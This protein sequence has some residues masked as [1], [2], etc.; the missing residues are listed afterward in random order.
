MGREG[1]A[2][3]LSVNHVHP[4]HSKFGKRQLDRVSLCCFQDTAIFWRGAATSA[5]RK[6]VALAEQVCVYN[7]H[8]CGKAI[9][10]ARVLKV[11][12]QLA[13]VPDSNVSFMQ[14]ELSPEGRQHVRGG[15]CIPLQEWCRYQVAACHNG[16]S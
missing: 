9:P 11:L 8:R 12:P 6:Q 1:L 14:W 13:A 10:C 5:Y 15:T 16:L 3:I 2:D 7:L 4:S